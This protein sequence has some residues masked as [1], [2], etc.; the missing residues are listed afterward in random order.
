MKRILV[1][2]KNSYIGSMFKKWVNQWPG[3]YTVDEISLRGEDWKLTDFSSYDVI[4]HLAGIAH[5]SSN[6]NLKEQYFLVNRDLTIAVAKKAKTDGVQ[7]FIFMSSIIVY[8][9]QH[10]L[11][12]EYTKPQPDDYYGESK[13]QAEEGILPLQDDSFDIAIIRPPMIYGKN[14]KGNYPRLSK[15]AQITPIFPN[16]ENQRSMLHIDN[17]TELIR[18]IIDNKDSGIFCPQNKEYV[19]TSDLVRK[20]AAVHGKRVRLTK[21]FNP[22]ISF[23]INVVLI[24]KVFGDLK[25]DT[26]LSKYRNGNY[27]KRDLI[28]SIYLTESGDA[29]L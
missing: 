24:K 3:K 27:Q 26:N 14:S 23:L 8:G 21:L 11:I 5:V 28:Q 9:T 2:G 15:L 1:T 19:K 22:V 29:Q 6:P 12:N 13:L 20:I 16:F 25:Y 10:E 18:L 4:L 7:Q 17:L